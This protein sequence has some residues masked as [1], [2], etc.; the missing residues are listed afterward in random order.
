MQE[1]WSPAC[2]WALSPA[3]SQVPSVLILIRRFNFTPKVQTLWLGKVLKQMCTPQSCG[4]FKQAL[5]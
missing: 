2:S 1:E 3:E 4:R 5:M